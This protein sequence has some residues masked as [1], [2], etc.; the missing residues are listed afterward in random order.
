MFEKNKLTSI[1]L[2][3][4]TLKG[5]CLESLNTNLIAAINIQ[6]YDIQSKEYQFNFLT[7]LLNLKICRLYFY[8]GGFLKAIKAFNQSK[9]EKIEECFVQEVNN[10][11]LEESDLE[12]EEEDEYIS[13]ISKLHVK[14]NNL[15]KL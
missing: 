1:K 8:D 14:Q 4:V 15:I 7:K 2:T 12:F 13:E 5:D 11:E 6:I 9:C 3:D 10:M